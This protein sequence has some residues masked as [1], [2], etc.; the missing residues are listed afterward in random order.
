MYYSNELTHYGILGM[1]WGIRRYQNP[2]GT[3]TPAGKKKYTSTRK[4]RNT[5]TDE[6][7]ATKIK[8]LET[9][10]KLKELEI[11]NLDPGMSFAFNILDSV[12]KKVLI[13]AIGG[14]ALYGAKML[15][16]RSG[17][18]VGDLADA[19]FRGGAKKK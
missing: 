19:V 1:K 8:R 10:V 7:L 6:E 4:E 11:K 16:D 5:L 18:D 9:E 2:D 14:A 17:F 3:L 12:G 13:T 15:I